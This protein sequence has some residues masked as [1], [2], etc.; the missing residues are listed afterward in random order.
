MI[1]QQIT[2][3]DGKPLPQFLKLTASQYNPPDEV[4]ELFNRVQRDYQVAYS[5][6]HRPFKEF[7]GYSLLD[8]ARL[9]QETF[10]AYVGCE[11]VPKQKAWR[12]KGRKNTSRNKLIQILAR[13]LAGMLYPYV[14]AQNEMNEE[15]K[16]SARVMRILIEEHLRKAGYEMKFLFL[17]ASALVNPAVFCFVEYV[18]AFQTI[19]QKMAGGK[20]KITEVVDEL[21]SGL[22]LNVL[23]ID[24]ILL[25]DYFSGTG[26]IQKLPNIIRLRRIPYDQA[27]AENAGKYFDKT[28]KDLFDYVEAGKT[29][30][31]LAGNENLTL[32]DIEWTEA[33]GNYVQELTAYYRSEDLE[34]KWIGGVGMLN[35]EDCYNTNPFNHRRM[36]LTKEEG[37]CS[38]PVY[39]V[40]MSGFEPLDPA[41]RFAWYKSGAFKEYWDD[42]GLNRMWQLAFDGTSLD[43]IK[44]QILSGV[45]KVDG[46][47]MSPGA[48]FGLPAGAQVTPYSMGPNLAAAYQALTKSETD[49]SAS[50]QSD[51]APSSPTPNVSATQTNAALAQ[52]RLFFNVFAL[53]LSDLIN[54]IGG[55]VMDCTIQYSTIGELNT[56]VSGVLGM[57]YK[58]FLSQGKDKGK[59]VSNKIVFSDKH[60]G[61]KYTKEQKTKY[62]W[63]LYDKTGGKDSDQRLYEVNPY[64]FAR[65]TY[66]MY[67]DADQIV[68]KST[69]A[70][71]AEKAL[72]FN[73]MTDP[74]VAPFTDPEA[75]A[76]DFVIEE[77]GGDDPDRYKK[78][79][80][81]VS[82]DMLSAIMNQGKGSP[83]GAPVPSGAAVMP[84]GVNAPVPSMQ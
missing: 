46:M 4:K 14:Y 77:Y 78:K 61:R 53:M 26:Q 30:V 20:V 66:A 58:T 40:A 56:N 21:L 54:Q 39:P 5:L 45:A 35:E 10:G 22:Q 8:R 59:N 49:I 81:A 13:T 69:G 32:Y 71:R 24:E 74:R 19:K 62:E 2:G 83:P 6:Q 60:M 12:W 25:P 70:D 75:V 27:K 72:A 18:E 3:A 50:T 84:P 73:M 38:I 44:P 29:R 17:V 34:V 47:V 65:L 9:D 7:D 31:F 76:T 57:K 51:P 41:G 42:Q 79:G 82:Q 80:P 55:L 64:Q 23:P 11:W 36:V 1:G 63:G 15:D 28:G 48:V 52:S 33:D 16:M 43:V 37:W 68:L 67:I